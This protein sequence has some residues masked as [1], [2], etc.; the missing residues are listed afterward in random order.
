[1]LQNIVYEMPQILF[2]KWWDIKRFLFSKY[3]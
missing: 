3:S 1:M 2:A